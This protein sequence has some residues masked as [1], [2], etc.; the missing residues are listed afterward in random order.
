MWDLIVAGD[1]LRVIP[2]PAYMPELNPV[3][4]VWSHVRRGLGTC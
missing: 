2:L 3:E 1:W 4:Q